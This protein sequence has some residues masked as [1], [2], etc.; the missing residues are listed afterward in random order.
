MNH[1][2]PRTGKQETFPCSVGVCPPEQS[3]GN[4][5]TLNQPPPDQVPYQGDAFPVPCFPQGDV[6][7][8]VSQ[9]AVI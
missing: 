9:F 8:A 7:N 3:T 4:L 1:H 2:S 6:S 5:F